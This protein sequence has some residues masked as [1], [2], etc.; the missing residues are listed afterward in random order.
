MKMLN[1]KFVRTLSCAAVA[2]H[3]QIAS[4]FLI[5]MFFTGIFHLFFR[6]HHDDFTRKPAKRAKCALKHILNS[7][8]DFISNHAFP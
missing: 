2:V 3:L 6:R 1:K 7:V 8:S 4:V 5:F